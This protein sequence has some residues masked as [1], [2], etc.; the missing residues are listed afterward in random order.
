MDISTFD[1]LLAAA[2]AQP[3][4]QRLLFVF[5]AIELPDDATPPS[6]PAF[7]QRPGRRAGA[8]DVRGQEPRR[9]G[10]RSTS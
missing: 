1:D 3:Q 6:A 4:P 2:R 9:A 8:A 7:E 10:T 5:A